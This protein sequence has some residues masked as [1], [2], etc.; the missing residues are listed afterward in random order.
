M[1]NKFLMTTAL[2]FAAT[3]TFAT[4]SLASGWDNTTGNWQY[5]DKSGVAVTDDWKYSN[6]NWFYLDSTGNLATNTLVE[7]NSNSKTKY[8]YVDQYGAMVTNTW[9][10]IAKDDNNSDLD[11]EYWWYYFGNDGAAYTTKDEL[12]TSDLKTINGFKYAFDD[13][14][15]MLYGWI[16][17]TN[18]EQQDNDDTAWMTSKYYFNGWNDGH[19]QTGWMQKT[20]TTA[21]NDTETYWFYFDNDGKKISDKNHKKING[22]YY[23]FAADG[24]MLDDW[25]VATNSVKDAG[26]ASAA[27][28]SYLN[29]D[30]AERKNQW[31]WAV[32]DEDYLKN[33][34]DD[35]EFSWWYFNKSGKLISNEIK[36]INSK[37]YAFDEFGRMKTGFVANIDGNIIAL[38]DADNLSRDNFLKGDLSEKDNKS[39]IFD[40]TSNT[41]YFF[42]QNEETDGSMQK[43]YVTVSLNDND[44]QFYFNTSNGVAYDGWVSKIKKYV[45][46]GLVVA[47]SA[48]DDSNY[49]A[50]VLNDDKVTDLVFG[51]DTVG[52]V[53][54]NTSGTIV[55]N[56]N[57]LKDKNDAYYVVNKDGIVLAYFD[58]EDNYKDFFSYE[59]TKT[60][61]DTDTKYVT[62]SSA[63]LKADSPA[64]FESM[65]Q[66]AIDKANKGKN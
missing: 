45:A 33:D 7:D 2:V 24:H 34:Y 6:G 49:G 4:A 14:G 35:E 60:N 50:V 48:D 41:L 47:P 38:D 20:V 1:K 17:E 16:N 66:N 21:D 40:R 32:P 44:Y 9:K 22:V 58:T 8:Y 31:V 15:H 42:N 28:L 26:K 52:H 64:A 12:N 56:K 30:G 53:L 23:H 63:M 5:L 43:G 11:A 57:K 19:M 54:V 25:A 29:K 3:L 10:A 51:S 65:V 37:K 55:K 46:N 18:V 13:E 61:G 59:Y 39:N 27:S 36:K 62:V